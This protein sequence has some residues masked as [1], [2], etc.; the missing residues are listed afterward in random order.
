GAG[1]QQWRAQ[2]AFIT[3]GENGLGLGNGRQK[4]GYLPEAHTDFIFS[5]IGE[6]LGLRFTLA[7][8]LCYIVIILCGVLIAMNARDRFGMLLGFGIVVIIGLQAVV[9]IGVNVSLLPNKGMPLPFVSYGGSNLLFCLLCVGILINIY[10][11]GLTEKEAQRGNMLRART[12]KRR[13]AVRL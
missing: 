8:V 3:G 5:M 9:N 7:I 13:L 1:L 6:E 12:R 10:R 11:Q 2:I 4:M